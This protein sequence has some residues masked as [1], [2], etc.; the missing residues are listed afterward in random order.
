MD[1]EWLFF[2]YTFLACIGGGFVQSTTG[3]GFGIFVMIFFPLYLPV[4]QASGLSGLI[5]I[6]LLG[7]LVWR[8][9]KYIQ[10]RAA[11]L[12]AVVYMIVSTTTIHLASSINLS[13]INFWLGI[14][15][16]LTAVYMAFMSG[17]IK[18][19]ANRGVAAFCAS[20]SGAMDGLFS[21]GGPPMTVYFLALLGNE[22]LKYLGTI[23]FFFLITNLVN[24]FNRFTS[25]ILESSTLLLAVPGIVGQFIGTRLGNRVVDRIDGRHFQILVYAFLAASGVFTCISSL[26]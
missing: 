23:Q 13:G 10:W 24:S 20:L 17:K 6:F 2:L 22:K 15:L 14:F 3:F 12:P 11:L 7:T 19:E 21:I 8:Y 18:V 5:V 26:L 9:H 16:L 4:L 1:N 25:D